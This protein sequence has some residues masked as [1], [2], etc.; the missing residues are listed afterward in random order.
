MR[1]GGRAIGPADRVNVKCEGKQGIEDA[2]QIQGLENW[3]GD[4]V[5]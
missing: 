2:V 5:C 4:A 1:V 3:V